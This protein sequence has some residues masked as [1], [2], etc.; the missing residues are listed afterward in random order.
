M[1][2]IAEYIWLGGNSE[3]RSKARTI[4]HTNP[5]NLN[6]FD[7][8]EWNYDGS[9]TKQSDGENSEIILKPCAVY[10]CP[11]REGNNYLVLC[12]TYD[13]YGIPLDNNNRVKANE[14][15]NKKI[16]E[17]PWYG[18][19]QEFFMIDMETKN[20]LDI[21]NLDLKGKHYCGI[22]IN[23]KTRKI[24]DE[25]YDACLYSEL[26][27]SGINAEVAVGQ[28]EYQIGPVCG[29]DASDQLWISRYIIQRIAEKYN[30]LIDFEPKPILG[31]IN[32][33]GCH[34]NFSTKSMREQNGLDIINQAIE[35]L[36]NKHIEHMNIYGK[37]NHLRMTGTCETSSYDKFSYGI[38]SRTSSI[39]IPT[40]TFYSKCGYFEDRRPS[41]NMDPYLVTS[42]IFET[43]CL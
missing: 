10:K 40:T 41:S 43:T 32:G 9:S 20:P 6:I 33:S 22:G 36:S 27:I 1:K 30:V 17:E 2:I 11:F 28:W 39:R 8:P 31:D 23:Y 3:L 5:Y 26:N 29:I 7:F 16:D 25:L 37:D 34:T 13:N 42:K 19:E 12:D 4:E 15:F 35:K 14:L 18:I 24:M 38:G 21:K